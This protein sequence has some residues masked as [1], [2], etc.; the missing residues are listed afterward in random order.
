M[1]ARLRPLALLVL[2][3]ALAGAPPSKADVLSIQD[4]RPFLDGKPFVE[5]SF[6][7]FDLFW[8]LYDLAKAGKPLDGGDPMVQAQDRALA[9]LAGMGLKTIRLFGMPWGN[10][11][12]ASNWADP[13]KKE[14]VFFAAVN[15]ALDLCEKNGIRAVY[16]L[17]AHEFYDRALVKGKWELGEEH[18]REL[19]RDPGSRSRKRLDAFLDEFIPRIKDRRAILMWEIGNEAT[20]AADIGDDKENIRNGHRQPTLKDVSDFYRDVSARIKRLDPLRLVNNGGSYMRES[21]WHRYTEKSWKLDTFEDQVKCFE[22]LFKGTGVDFIDIHSYPNHRPGYTIAGPDGGETILDHSGYMEIA[23]RIGKPLMIGELG[24]L[25]QLR[26][27]KKIWDA[28]PDYFESWTEVEQAKKWVQR[29]VDGVV[30]AGVP[31]VYWWAYSSDRA[32]DQKAVDRMD[33]AKGRNDEILAILLDGNRR[34]KA[35]LGAP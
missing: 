33:L 20:L 34:L 23:R 22:L 3:A 35:K 29:A 14:K 15:K 26:K 13:E 17:A 10:W 25:P 32:M 7:K 16:S 19:L 24:A 21:Q 6:N 4:G 11:D 31:L 27:N 2:V 5:L 12:F 8:Q 1:R 9:E 28:A 18:N 30:E